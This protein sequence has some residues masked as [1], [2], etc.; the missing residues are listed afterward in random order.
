MFFLSPWQSRNKKRQKGMIKFFFLA[1]SFERNGGDRVSKRA[2]EET[3]KQSNK[4][5]LP[6]NKNP[7]FYHPQT[8]ELRHPRETTLLMIAQDNNN[9]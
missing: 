7:I 1:S 8:G 6:S 9:K 5:S 2:I 4:L 3:N